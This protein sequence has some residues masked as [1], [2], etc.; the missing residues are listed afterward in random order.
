MKPDERDAVVERL[1]KSLEPPQPPPDLRSKA[2]AAARSRMSAD[3]I[4]DFWSRVWNHRGLRQ[5]WAATVVLLVSGHA[6]VAPGAGNTFRPVD[7]SLTAENR[8]DDYLVE[9]LRPA[10]ISDNVRPIVGLIAS[11]GLAEIDGEGNPL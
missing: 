2:L 6:Q 5:A 3:P 7:P 4:P 11:N 8:V 1:M 10:R 9:M